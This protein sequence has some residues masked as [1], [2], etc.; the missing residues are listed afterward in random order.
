MGHRTGT[1]KWDIEMGNMNMTQTWDSDGTQTGLR[2]DS[3]G[4]QTC[5]IETGQR[6]GT[7]E[8]FSDMGHRNKD[9]QS[10]DIEIG[11]ICK[12]KGT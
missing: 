3:D 10:W 9:M 12:H 11:H 4:T 6:N 2:R 7:Q 1:K 8:W 5:D